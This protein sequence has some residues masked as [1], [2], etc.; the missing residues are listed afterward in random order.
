MN[1]LKIRSITKLDKYGHVY[2]LSVPGNHN[3]YIGQTGIMTSNCDFL[4]PNAQAALR[5]IIETFSKHTRF[6]FTCNYIERLIDPIKSRLQVFELTAPHKNVVYKHLSKILASENVIYDKND[7]ITVINTEYP[8][9]RKIIQTCQLYTNNGEFKLD[10]QTLIASN[11]I[12]QV[13]EVLKNR[14]KYKKPNEAIKE[15]RQIIADSKV[16]RF[17]TL[18]RYLFDNI[19]EYSNGADEAGIIIIIAEAQYQ[20]AFAVDAEINI[21][22]MFTRL[23]DLMK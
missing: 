6:I 3:F 11:Y 22:A 5:N 17:E 4:S 9:I 20:A 8:D 18:I 16:K 13:I 10:K 15:I 23:L 19:Q 2:D 7:L 1:K 12:L 21:I 14:K